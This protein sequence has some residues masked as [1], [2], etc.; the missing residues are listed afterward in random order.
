MKRNAEGKQTKISICKLVTTSA[1]L[2]IRTVGLTLMFRQYVKYVLSNK[3]GG[4]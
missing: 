3:K 4:N 2:V 1:T